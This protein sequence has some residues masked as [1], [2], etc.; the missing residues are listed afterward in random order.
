MEKQG[1]ARLV[2]VARMLK[3]ITHTQVYVLD[4][5]EALDFYVGKQPKQGPIEMPNPAESAAEN[6]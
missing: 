3:S 5:D 4:Q 2:S 6:S 1:G